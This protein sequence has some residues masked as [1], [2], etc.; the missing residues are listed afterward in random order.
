MIIKK[1]KKIT[2]FKNEL[3]CLRVSLRKCSKN[4]FLWNFS[5]QIRLNDCLTKY[6]FTWKQYSS[7]NVVAHSR[8]KMKILCIFQK[9]IY[10]VSHPTKYSNVYCLTG[11][12]KSTRFCIFLNILVS[13]NV[14]WKRRLVTFADLIKCTCFHT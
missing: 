11:F 4:T 8:I 9:S 3:M 13:I 5:D 1:I 7:K 10:L 12:F 2:I 14:F 6:F